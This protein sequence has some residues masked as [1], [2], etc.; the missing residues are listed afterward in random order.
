[1][2]TKHTAANIP[3][4]VAE[5]LEIEARKSNRTVEEQVVHIL[6]HR[7]KALQRIC[8]CGFF[9]YHA[10]E[11]HRCDE[12]NALCCSHCSAPQPHEIVFCHACCAKKGIDP[13]QAVSWRIPREGKL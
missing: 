6:T 8:E 3:Q 1:M 13:A 12:C 10:S 9:V 5:L 7:Y 11:I 4:P 2:V